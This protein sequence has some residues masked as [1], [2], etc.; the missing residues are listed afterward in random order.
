[1]K[2]FAKINNM[3]QQNALQILMTENNRM[4]LG[5]MVN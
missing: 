4:A 3:H 2:F 1:M 5:A